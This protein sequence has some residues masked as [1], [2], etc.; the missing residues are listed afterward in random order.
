GKGDVTAEIFHVAYTL[1]P[2]PSREPDPRR[3]VTFVFNG[4]P[5]AASAYLHLG[6]LGPRVMAT[7]DNGSF[8]PSPQRLL[9]NPNTWLDMTD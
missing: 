5:G 4:G 7:A 2:E 8:L 9:D 1:R 3:P 6:A